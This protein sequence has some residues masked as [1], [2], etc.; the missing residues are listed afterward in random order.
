[1]IKPWKVKRTKTVLNSP[2]FVV[3]QDAVSLPDGKGDIEYFYWTDRD[4]VQIIPLT[5]DGK[6][7]LERQ[8]KHGIEQITIELPAGYIEEGET[9]LAA[10]KRELTEETG[11]EAGTYTFITKTAHNPSKYRSW[12][13]VYL[14]RDIRKTGVTKFDIGENIETFLIPLDEAIAMIHRKEITATST[15]ASLFLAREFLLKK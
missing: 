5:T 12:H 13:H 6:V 2:W 4:I 11:Y 10:A 9:P 3:R 15:I 8:Y 1:M 14:A 7:L